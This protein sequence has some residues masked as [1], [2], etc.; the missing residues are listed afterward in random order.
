MDEREAALTLED[1]LQQ[2]LNM[3]ERASIML[4]ETLDDDYFAHIPY[5]KDLHN[6]Y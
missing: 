1:D 3:A 4:R 2:I 6:A 5:D